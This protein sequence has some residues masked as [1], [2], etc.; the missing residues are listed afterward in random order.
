MDIFYKVNGVTLPDEYAEKCLNEGFVGIRACFDRS[1]EEACEMTQQRFIDRYWLEYYS[2]HEQ[3]TVQYAKNVVSRSWYFCSPS[4]NDNAYVLFVTKGSIIHV[5]HICGGYRYCEGERRVHQR[6]VKWTGVAFLRSDM[7]KALAKSFFSPYFSYG[8]VDEKFNAELLELVKGNRSATEAQQNMQSEPKKTSEDMKQKDTPR[9]NTD[10]AT[11]WPK[12]A[13]QRPLDERALQQSLDNL[14]WR[15]SKFDPEGK[16]DYAFLYGPSCNPSDYAVVKSAFRL[17]GRENEANGKKIVEFYFKGN[18]YWT[19]RNYL[20]ISRVPFDMENT[21]KASQGS[22]NQEISSQL[23]PKPHTIRIAR[24]KEND[25][26]K[27]H[28]PCADE[29]KEYLTKWSQSERAEKI[30]RALDNL[31]MLYCPKNDT[32]ED[33]LVKCS[34]LNDFYSTNIFDVYSVA[35]HY[36]KQNIDER[37]AQLDA[38]LPND[39]T[40]VKVGEKVFHFYSFATKYCSHHCPKDYPMYD[41]YVAKVLCYFRDRDQFFIFIDKELRD[42]VTYLTIMKR[43]RLHYGLTAFNFKELDKYLWQLGREAFATSK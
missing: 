6:P 34:A 16:T 18:K 23:M 42:Y 1:L 9:E 25:V 12:Y 26:L 17:L 13:P 39:L 15:K 21:E 27:T 35:Q 43:F 37:L 29:V 10:D 2:D 11:A 14:F 38:T 19:H 8:I 22:A 7:S 40:D 24:Y 32:M 31:F 3:T 28:R 33:I 4:L 30:E 5:G 36:L 20:A 41:S